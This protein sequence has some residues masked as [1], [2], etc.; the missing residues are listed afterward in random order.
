[1]PACVIGIG[2]EQKWFADVKGFEQVAEFVWQC[3]LVAICEFDSFMNAPAQWYGKVGGA[4]S[5]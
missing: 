5:N 2:D 1:M 4:S 3:P